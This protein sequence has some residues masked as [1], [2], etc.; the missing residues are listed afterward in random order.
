MSSSNRVRVAVIPEVLLGITP[1]T[2]NF[3]TARYTSESLSGT[4][5][6]TESAQIRSDRLSSGQ[7]LTGLEV[8]GD[9]GFELSKDAT[10][11]AMLESVMYSSWSVLPLVSA[12]LSINIDVLTDPLHPRITISR[13]AGDFAVDLDIGDIFRTTGFTN[14]ENNT[15][16]QVLEFVSP[17]TVRVNASQTIGDVVNEIVTGGSF[18]RADRLSIGTTQKSFSIEKA[19]L[20]LSNKALIYRGQIANTFNVSVAYGEVVTGSI[21]FVGTDRDQA[22]SLAEFITTGRTINPSASTSSLNGSIDMPFISSSSLG[23][24][25]PVDFCIQSLSID[26]D[27][28]NNAQNC[29][30]KIGPKNFSAGS[31][32]VSVSLSAYLAD[33]TWGVLAR[34]LDQTAFSLGFLIKNAEGGYG[35]YLPAVQ[36]SFSDPSVSGANTDISLEMDGVGRAGPSGESTLYIFRL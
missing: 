30:G 22:D 26:L 11:E 7:I 14:V 20:D 13:V 9:L 10:F 23:E 15:Y 18:K 25:S 29:I 1:T 32:S 34:K 31:A 24:L 28:N 21:G 27:N 33:D 5:T 35:F 17:T 3:S 6:T 36:V 4:P 16:F 8:G 19:F 2:G 12:D